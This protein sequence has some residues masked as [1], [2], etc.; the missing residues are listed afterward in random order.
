MLLGSP[1]LPN[2][3]QQNCNAPSTQHAPSPTWCR[4]TAARPTWAASTQLSSHLYLSWLRIHQKKLN[5][6]IDML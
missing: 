1:E 2:A 5:N 4:P 3:E 6:S